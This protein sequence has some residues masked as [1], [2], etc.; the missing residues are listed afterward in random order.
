MHDSHTTRSPLRSPPTALHAHATQ[1]PPE[2]ELP[3]L[4][5][6]PAQANQA[7]GTSAANP[8]LELEKKHALPTAGWN[9]ALRL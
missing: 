2:R 9:S 4:D 5:N 6:R 1:W 8:T 3:A 7:E